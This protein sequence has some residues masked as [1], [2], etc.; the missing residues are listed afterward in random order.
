MEQADVVDRAAGLEPGSPVFKL[1]RE[2]QDI[3]QATQ[4]SHDALLLPAE[5]G[6]FS[7]AE[8][9]RVAHLV[10]ERSG[11]AALA[12]HYRALAGEADAASPRL[13]AKLR[14][15]EMLTTS[16]RDATR[17]SIERLQ[18]EGLSV[19]DIVTLSQL[20]ALVS[21]QVRVVAGLRQMAAAPV[22]AAA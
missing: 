4:G 13:D 18:A 16:P 14:H 2:R 5:P 11:D 12:A 19:A 7:R 15:A 6:G 20:V 22:G 1:R 9:A 10:A 17:A 8:R 21:H 3:L